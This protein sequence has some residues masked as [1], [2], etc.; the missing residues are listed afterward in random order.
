MNEVQRQEQRQVQSPVI[1]YSIL[2]EENQKIMS[3][4]ELASVMCF[5]R[6]ERFVEGYTIDEDLYEK[7]MV[8]FGKLTKLHEEGLVRQYYLL[9]QYVIKNNLIGL[10]L[11]GKYM[12]SE[13]SKFLHNYITQDKKVINLSTQSISNVFIEHHFKYDE[14]QLLCKRTTNYDNYI[15]LF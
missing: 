14:V 11:Y 15:D 7:I 10:F 13:K 6:K 8:F 9:R 1:A 3:K 12:N 4:Q 2:P 5:L